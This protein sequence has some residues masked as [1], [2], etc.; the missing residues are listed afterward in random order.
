MQE[1]YPI[2]SIRPIWAY[3]ILRDGKDIENRTWQTSYRGPL[4]IHVSKT[5]ESANEKL[6]FYARYPDARIGGVAGIVDLVNCVRDHR[7][8]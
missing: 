7:S 4:Y 8:R 1:L 6:R 5:F 2:L 3:Q